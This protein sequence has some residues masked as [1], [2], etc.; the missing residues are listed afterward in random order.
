MKSKINVPGIPF[1]VKSRLSREGITT[2]TQLNTL[3]KG[4]IEQL[5]PR[6]KTW[7]RQ[8]MTTLKNGTN[9]SDDTKE[10]KVSITKELLSP[11]AKTKI[12]P[13]DMKMGM[14]DAIN[15][16][17]SKDPK[18]LAGIAAGIR[19]S[20]ANPNYASGV[21]L[22]LHEVRADSITNV[23]GMEEIQEVWNSEPV[24]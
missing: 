14:Q 19:M 6:S 7:V 4:R 17:N 3:S 15:N 24:S 20:A 12:L 23:D 22:G 8:Y 2:N 16:L 1:S 10:S 13:F 11:H 9:G 5:G 21:L 18:F